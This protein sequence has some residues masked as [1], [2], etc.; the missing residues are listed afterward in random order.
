MTALALGLLVALS[1]FAAALVALATPRRA[2]LES[3]VAPHVGAPAAVAGTAPPAGGVARALERLFERTE[4]RLAG[5][6]AWEALGCRIERAGM[7]VRPASFLWAVGGGGLALGALLTLATGSGA[8]LL[9][10]P[11]A[12]LGCAW[13]LVSLR[14]AR[15]LRAFDEQ[16][17]ELLG[18]LSGSLRAGHSFSHALEAAAADAGP[19]AGEELAR[20]LAEARLGRPIDEALA[21]LAQR[22]PS[23]DLTFVLTAVT[24]QRQVGGSLASLFEVVHETVRQRQQFARKVRGL[25][26]M[27]RAS[28]WVLVAV[29]VAVGALLTLLNPG[30]MSPL[31]TTGVGRMLLVTSTL[32]MAVGGLVLRRIVAFKG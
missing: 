31:V 17:P 25:T 22:M 27:G 20:V 18:V 16:L 6:R 23:E 29:P 24:I 30:Y 3:R 32:S 19:P 13:A 15:R 4:T 21:R 9:V 2:W 28:A 12:V 8:L 26:A 5:A 11:L 1:T 7:R 10:V 14:A